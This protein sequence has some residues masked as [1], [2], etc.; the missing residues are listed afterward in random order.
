MILLTGAT[1]S[2]GYELAKLLSTHAV[3]A[4]AMVRSD[5]AAEKLKGLTGIEPVP[6]D[7]DDPASLD[8]ALLSIERAFLLTNSTE[9]AVAFVDIPPEAMRQA[10][11]EAGFPCGRWMA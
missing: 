9:R 4:K 5:A 11:I 8:A 1:G 3:A 10:V 7:F 6:G 2:V